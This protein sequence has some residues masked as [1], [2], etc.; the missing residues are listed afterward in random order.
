MNKKVIY[1]TL[2]TSLILSTTSFADG[3]DA[4][5]FAPQPQSATSG[6]ETSIT[7]GYHSKYIWRGLDLGNDMVDFSVETSTT[8]AGIDLTAGIWQARSFD[9]P[10]GVNQN[11][12]DFYAEAAKDLGFATVSVGYIFYHFSDNQDDADNAQEVYFGLSKDIAGI[13]ASLTYY[14]DVETDN[15]GYLE[16]GLEKSMYGLDASVTTGYL[17]EEGALSHVT[18]TISKSFELPY[19]ITASP[20][21]SYIVE[22]DD[23]ETLSGG[24]NNALIGGLSFSYSF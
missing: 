21:I 18:S 24:Q 3:G 14:W 15:N 16:L 13:S 22:L 10:D 7:T 8:Y 2:A 1:S 23:L 5:V 20:Y 6:F 12:T 4:S 19:G 17:I 9:Q 11:E